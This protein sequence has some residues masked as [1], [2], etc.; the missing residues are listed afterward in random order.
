M[1]RHK[2]GTFADADLS[3]LNPVP[4]Y[5]LALLIFVIVIIKFYLLL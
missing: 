2:S 1:K 5:C 4:V 3:P